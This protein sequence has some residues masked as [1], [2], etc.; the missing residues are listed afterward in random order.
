M[1][2]HTE[3]C[4]TRISSRTILSPPTLYPSIVSV[5][6]SH[7]GCFEFCTKNGKAYDTVTSQ[8]FLSKVT[9]ENQ[10]WKKTFS[11]G[12][13]TCTSF[14]CENQLSQ[15]ERVLFL[16]VFFHIWWSVIGQSEICDV[17]DRSFMVVILC[18]T[19]ITKSLLL[20]LLSSICIQNTATPMKRHF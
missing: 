13:H 7:V 19:K 5:V 4:A 16:K 14:A 15:I 8:S 9:F 12:I 11:C 3:R 2:W 18:I 10:F 17:I 6:L 20:M 1:D